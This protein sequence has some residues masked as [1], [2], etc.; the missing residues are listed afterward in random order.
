MEPCIFRRTRSARVAQFARGFDAGAQVIESPSA[1]CVFR[2]F[3][4]ARGADDD[5]IAQ[6]AARFKTRATNAHDSSCESA[7]VVI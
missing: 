6:R 3:L 1:R 7:R 4:R 2:I 5:A